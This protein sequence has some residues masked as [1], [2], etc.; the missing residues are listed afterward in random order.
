VSDDAER[1]VMT[2]R[3]RVRDCPTFQKLAPGDQKRIA[4]ILF[5]LFP[6]TE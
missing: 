5:V 3:D 6:P 4:A 2:A 1:R